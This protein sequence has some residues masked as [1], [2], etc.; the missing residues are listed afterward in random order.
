MPELRL[1]IISHK[2]CK[3]KVIAEACK[4]SL[5]NVSP[6]C[7]SETSGQYAC[8]APLSDTSN[9]LQILPCKFRDTDL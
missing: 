1:S 4:I 3:I 5:D 8:L 2:W 9:L 6:T 7:P